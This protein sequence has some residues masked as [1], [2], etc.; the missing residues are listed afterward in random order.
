MTLQLYKLILQYIHQVITT[1]IKALP[2]RNKFDTIS[3]DKR[4][5]LTFKAHFIAILFI[6]RNNVYKISALLTLA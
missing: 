5:F 2:K 4:A 6:I 1:Y 3:Q